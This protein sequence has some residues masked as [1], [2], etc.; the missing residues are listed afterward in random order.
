MTPQSR[1]AAGI[2]LAGVA[3]FAGQLLAQG[4]GD[5]AGSGSEQATAATGQQVY[6]QICQACHMPAAEGGDGAGTIPALAR[7]AHL[8][9]GD[10]AVTMVL[11]G[12]GGMPAFAGMLKPEQVAGVVTYLRTNF[13]NAYPQPVT[14]DDVKRL[15]AGLGDAEE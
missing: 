10:Y 3:A 7:N 1:V 11:R 14:V 2:V 12:K 5:T 15:S 4:I 13:G 9:D 8:A 6:R